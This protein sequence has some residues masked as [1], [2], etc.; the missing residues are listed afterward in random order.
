MD[1][2]LSVTILKNEL[3]ARF[4]ICKIESDTSEEVRRSDDTGVG[5]S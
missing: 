1:L 2:K 5:A 3:V 4:Y